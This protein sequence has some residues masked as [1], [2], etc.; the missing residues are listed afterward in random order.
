[1]SLDDSSQVRLQN[2]GTERPAHQ[3]SSHIPLYPICNGCDN[4]FYMNA[5]KQTT[6]HMSASSRG[7]EIFT[8][9][10]RRVKRYSAVSALMSPRVRNPFT[11]TLLLLLSTGTHID[12]Q[13][14]DAILKLANTSSPYPSVR[15]KQA[16]KVFIFCL[17][18]IQRVPI[19][20]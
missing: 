9:R 14:T 18:M 2:L 1:M 10:E 5:P 20:M 3:R 16:T 4:S 19:L 15:F 12:A 11:C 13:T 6:Q 17:K 8:S 7:H